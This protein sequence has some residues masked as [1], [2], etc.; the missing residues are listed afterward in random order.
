MIKVGQWGE[1]VA[2]IGTE[3]SNKITMQHLINN[4]SI[5]LRPVLQLNRNA[6]E[7][8]QGE[9]II[10][11]D[12]KLFTIIK[13]QNI[14]CAIISNASINQNQGRNLETIDLLDQRR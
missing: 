7:F 4:K 12:Q 1:P 2:L 6:E 11:S 3:E 10:G 9:L 14:R 8:N 13:E 5:G